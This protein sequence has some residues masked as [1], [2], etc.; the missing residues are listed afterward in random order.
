[1]ERQ[2]ITVDIAPGNSQV[3]RLGTSQGDI[4]R[5]MGVYIIQ[6]GVA[7]DCSAYSAELYILKPDGKFYTTQATVDA[8]ETNLIKWDTALQETPVAGAC[9]AQIRIASGDDDIGTARFVEFVEASPGDMGSASESEVAL[10]TEYVRQARESATSAGRDATTASDAASS[11]SGSASTASAAAST[12]TQAASAAEAAADRAEEVEESIPADY[13]QMSADVT[14]LKSAFEQLDANVITES[15]GPSPIVSIA[16][17]A[18][19]MPMRSVEVAIEPVQDLHGYEYPWPAG[20]GKNLIP[21]IE[22]TTSYNVTFSQDGDYINISGTPS[23]NARCVLFDGILPTGTYTLNGVTG[24]SNTSF[25]TGLKIDDDT[26][27]AYNAENKRTFT[28]EEDSQVLIWLFAYPGYGT[29][30]NFK[31]QYQLE[32]GDTVTQW[33]PYSNVCPISG[34][35][36]VTITRAGVNILDLTTME[37][38]YYNANGE[39]VAS[40][41]LKRTATIAPVNPGDRYSLKFEVSNNQ[42]SRLRV[43]EYD[44]SGTWLRQIFMSDVLNAPTVYEK[45]LTVSND[46]YFIA[47]SLP[48]YAYLIAYFDLDTYHITFPDSAG[49]VYGGPLD[50]VSGKLVVDRAITDLGALSWQRITISYGYYFVASISDNRKASG[51]IMCSAYK[52]VGYGAAALTQNC[53]ISRS[54][55]NKNVFVRD[56]SYSTAEDF[57]TAVSGVQLCYYLE[58]PISI[59]LDPVVV[60]SLLGENHIFA[61]AGNTSV[62]Y[63]ADTKMYIDRKITEAV[64]NA[65]NA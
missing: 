38:G 23:S 8:T 11:A 61:D 63:P 40:L 27:W 55:T 51:D 26:S 42:N 59:Q 36:G 21:P 30:D 20:G 62:T 18:D 31:V 3:E 41:G 46:A 47:F 12:A 44:K 49:T 53:T 37:S 22:T 1:M 39:K 45:N 33:T 57:K 60:L 19:G 48:L 32:R 14:S 24:A 15:A 25:R 54:A 64:A 50:V 58:E 2:V 29:F 10:L 34:H 13:S 56:D 35:T 28:L 6:N 17:G 16:D 43:H 5:P 7:L 52:F 9:A 65:L 4:G